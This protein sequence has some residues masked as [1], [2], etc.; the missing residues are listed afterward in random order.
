MISET[1]FSRSYSSFW[2]NLLPWLNSF[3]QSLNKSMRQRI[4]QP[5][6]QNE[7]SGFR[8]INNIISFTHYCNITNNPDY[9]IS[10]SISEA[11][12]YA[13]RFPRSNVDSYSFTE[14]HKTIVNQQVKNLCTLYKEPDFLLPIFPGCGIIDNCFGDI[15]TDKCLVEVKAGERGFQPSDLRQLIVYLSLNWINDSSYQ[16][17]K[18][19]LYNPRMGFYWEHDINTFF[20]SITDVVKEDVFDQLTKYLLIESQDVLL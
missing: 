20:Q 9:E 16:I 15:L 2:I 11:L 17:G 14:I 6:D 1:N 4:H 8:S 5:I 12:K 3:C 19:S 18:I 10:D 7:S 13:K